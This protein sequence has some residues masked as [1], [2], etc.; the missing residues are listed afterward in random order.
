MQLLH[1]NGAGHDI[2]LDLTPLQGITDGLLL[3]VDALLIT[4]PTID[5]IRRYR[6]NRRLLLLPQSELKESLLFELSSS[7]PPCAH[8]IV[9]FLQDR[10]LRMRKT[11]SDW[12]MLTYF[13]SNQNSHDEITMEALHWMAS[14]YPITR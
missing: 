12:T 2:L 13:T 8:F 3:L 4:A 5:Y 7:V 6:V 9:P 11:T 10:R 14:Q 1:R